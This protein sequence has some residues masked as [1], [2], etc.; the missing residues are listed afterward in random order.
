VTFLDFGLVKHFT[1]AELLPFETLIRAMV[2]EPNIA[3]FRELV[4]DLGLLKRD[5]PFS[6]ELVGEYFGHFYELV[7]TPGPTRITPEYA[8]ETVRRYFDQSG[9]YG[10]IMRAASVPSSFVLIQRINL[11]LNAVLGEL[12][13]TADWRALA[14][15][16]WPFVAATPSTGMGRAIEQ[17][18]A[19]RAAVTA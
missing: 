10:E 9:P 12:D 17:W 15:E 6:D 16:L 19:A 14:E 4:E 13:A 8:S 11:G 3:H 1:A 2:L 7:A 18:Q 5:Q